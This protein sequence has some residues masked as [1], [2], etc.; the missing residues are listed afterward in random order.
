MCL[1]FISPLHTQTPDNCPNNTFGLLFLLGTHLQKAPLLHP[2]F[3]YPR[4]TAC[5]C[6]LPPGVG[7]GEMLSRLR[8]KKPSTT[9]PQFSVLTPG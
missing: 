4:Q 9:L 6:S 2:V 3:E 1:P 7:E 5:T 8:P